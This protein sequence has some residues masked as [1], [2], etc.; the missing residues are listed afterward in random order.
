MSHIFAKR[1]VY[2]DKIP[3]E[4]KRNIERIQH[5]YLQITKFSCKSI[6]LFSW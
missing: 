1:T 2:L 6:P 5:L 3:T 4:N